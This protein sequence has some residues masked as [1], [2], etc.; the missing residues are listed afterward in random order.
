MQKSIVV[1]MIAAAA[2][3]LVLE[4][5]FF[6]AYLSYDFK[7]FS[8]KQAEE[9]KQFIYQTEQ[10]SLKDI[11]QM[12]YTTIEMFHEQATNIDELK[13]QKADRLKQVVDTAYSLIMR[14]YSHLKGEISREKLIEDLK[15][16]AAHIRYEGDNYV[17]INDLTPR[18]VIHP[19]N[20]GLNGKDLS[21]Y[22]DPNGKRLFVEMAKIAKEKGEGMV[23]YLWAKPGETTPKP[24]VSYVK[25]IPELNWVVGTGAWIEDITAALQRQALDQISKM[26]LGDGNYL[27]VQDTDTRMVMH[28]MNPGLDGKDVSQST[29]AK[30]NRFFAEMTKK[31]TQDGEGYVTYWWT[32]P[33]Q[34][35]D[36]PKLSYIKLFKA[37]NWILGMGVYMDDVDATVNKNREEFDSA[38]RTLLNNAMLFGG[39]FMILCVAAITLL[40]RRGLKRP[41]DTV[42]GYADSVAS[43]DLDASMSGTFKGEILKLKLSIETMVESLKQKMKEAQQKSE[44]AAEEADRAR[45]AQAEA[46]E[47]RLR[48]ESAKREGMLQAA[49]TLEGIVTRV[50]TASDEMS[51]QAE[52]INQSTG[53]QKQRIGETATAMEEM[54]A[55]VL[56]VARNAS[57]AAENAESAKQKALEG[58]EVV[59][60]SIEAISSIHEMAMVL[61]ADMD[62]LGGQAEAIGQ[63][64]TVITDIADQTNLLALNAAIEAARAGDAGRGFAVVADEVRKLAEKTMSA[65]KEVGDSIAAIQ[66][67]T[68]KNTQNVDRAVQAVEQA[69]EL[70][71]ISGKSLQEIVSL[72][73]STAD[74][75]RNI[76]TASEEQSAA[77]EEINRVVEEVNELSTSIAE[78]MDQSYQALNELAAQASELSGLI[79]NMKDDNT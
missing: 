7:S 67:S 71:D 69:N 31:A 4:A 30:G 23:D 13:I 66:G 70:A 52:E 10:F 45:V 36:F 57:S 47:A 40:M 25:L 48:A 63:I 17:W 77:S 6:Y 50:S 39:M 20:P 74:Q 22:K 49:G 28:P 60:K 21:D 15:D 78:A 46:E 62:V 8:A 1:R 53:M 35:G 2:V 72:S 75:V 19:T 64:M 32:K 5:L 56:E 27:W 38:M 33:G 34:S 29:D 68:E 18:M 14:H 58:R 12:A 73:E 55:T 11:V 16:L 79:Q 76:A 9:T 26:R 24:K 61:K 3:A 37:W 54:N 43:G 41:M 44:E 59:A 51:S 42:V 65:T